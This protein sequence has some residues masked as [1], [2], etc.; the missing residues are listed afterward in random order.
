METNPH[1][2]QRT[3]VSAGKTETTVD[4]L[5]FLCYTVIEESAKLFDIL[6]LRIEGL[7]DVSAQ[8]TLHFG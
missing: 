8:P 2:C 1:Y 6:I 7:L 4:S 3:V 5:A